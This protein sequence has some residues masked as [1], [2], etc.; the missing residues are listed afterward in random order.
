VR[1]QI[2]SAMDLAHSGQIN[3]SDGRATILRFTSGRLLV[4]CG[5]YFFKQLLADSC[6]REYDLRVPDQLCRV[7]QR[8][9]KKGRNSFRQLEGSA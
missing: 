1:S 3:D 4:G 6:E 9:K 2:D 5:I 8:K 7:V